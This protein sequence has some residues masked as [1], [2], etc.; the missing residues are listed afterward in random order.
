[1]AAFAGSRRAGRLGGLVGSAKAEEEA[2]PVPWAGGARQGWAS[3]YKI[4]GGG[5]A[6][7]SKLLS[8]RHRS[9]GVRILDAYRLSTAK[10]NGEIQFCVDS[11][12]MTTGW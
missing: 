11:Y 9:I 3:R 8:K 12:V 1:M 5:F 10:H 6:T 2:S 4:P 7:S